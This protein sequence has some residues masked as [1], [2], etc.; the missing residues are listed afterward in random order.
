MAFHN[1]TFLSDL[2]LSVSPLSQLSA[3]PFSSHHTLLLQASYL[4]PLSA[5]IF[6]I[7]LFVKSAYTIGK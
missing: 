5:P 4:S 6:I 7:F 2:V 3:Q 1:L